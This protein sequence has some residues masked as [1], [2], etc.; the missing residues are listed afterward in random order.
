[1]TECV[2]QPFDVIVLAIMSPLSRF[3]VHKHARMH[4]ISK[5]DVQTSSQST[6]WSAASINIHYIYGLVASQPH[7][8]K[9]TMA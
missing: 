8:E 4:N 3:S 9:W 6:S 5:S 1:M 7:G 2:A